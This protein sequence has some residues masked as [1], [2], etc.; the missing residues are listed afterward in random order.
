MAGVFGRNASAIRQSR[1][2]KACAGEPERALKET[3]TRRR[4]LQPDTLNGGM[5][6]ATGDD[7]TIAVFVMA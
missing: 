5:R 6:A 3:M 7:C 2:R 4:L 1:I